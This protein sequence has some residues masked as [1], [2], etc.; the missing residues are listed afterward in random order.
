MNSIFTKFTPPKK[1]QN[2]TTVALQHAV[3][4]GPV[5]QTFG[6]PPIRNPGYGP[7]TYTKYESL[8]QD[9]LQGLEFV[10]TCLN[11]EIL[12]LCLTITF[13]FVEKTLEF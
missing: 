8:I 11:T 1:A 7:V 9:S 6:P 3:R 12:D 5:F 10:A 2:R 4:K 13:N